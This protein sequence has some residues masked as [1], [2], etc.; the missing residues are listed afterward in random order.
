MH[1]FNKYELDNLL[2]LIATDDLKAFRVLYDSY[3]PQVYSYSYFLTRSGVQAED[4]AQDIFVKIWT[5]RSELTK[6]E[7]FDAWLKVLVRNQAYNFLKK[8][9]V[10]Q[11][12][13]RKL[14][15][16]ANQTAAPADEA[17][18]EKEYSRIYQQAINQ[19]PPQ[20]KKVY[21]LSRKD[22]L[23]H[24]EIAHNLGLSLNTVKNHMKAALFSIRTFLEG[25]VSTWLILAHLY[26]FV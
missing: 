20:Q 15:R 4:L 13:L 7:Q 3:L 24:E 6:I 5:K 19:L 10:E 25:Y 12:S 26:L 22:G 1:P 23:K 2:G 14:Y 17:L 18:E 11:Y 8:S 9:A 16:S 21:L